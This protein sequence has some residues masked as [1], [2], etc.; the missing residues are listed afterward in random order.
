MAG[1]HNGGPDEHDC[2]TL[3]HVLLVKESTQPWP[4]EEMQFLDK[5][6]DTTPLPIS[7]K[8]F[9]DEPS[10]AKQS[11]FPQSHGKSLQL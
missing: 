7:E 3:P 2:Q 8:E 11:V 10:A 5:A 6:L 9:V 1:D 4:G